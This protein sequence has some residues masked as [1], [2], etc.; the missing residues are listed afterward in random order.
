M[1]TINKLLKKQAPKQR[2]RSRLI[3][4]GASTTGAGDIT[5]NIPES[6][7]EKPDPVFVR[8]ISSTKGSL[9]GVPQEWSGTPFGQVF[10]RATTDHLRTKKKPTSISP[11]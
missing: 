5:P 4:S 2:G 1:D 11:L 3:E 8:W 9:V 6:A 7:S 10:E